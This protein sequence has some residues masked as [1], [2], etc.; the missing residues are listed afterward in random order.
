MKNPGQLSFLKTFPGVQGGCKSQIVPEILGLSGHSVHSHVITSSVQKRQLLQ[1]HHH[2]GLHCEYEV[3]L[4]VVVLV[5]T[6]ISVQMH[7]VT[8]LY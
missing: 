5:L 7:V 1:V 3:T 8:L 2:E 6:F 4:H